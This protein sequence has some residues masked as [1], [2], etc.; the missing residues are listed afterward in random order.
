M[1]RNMRRVAL[2]LC[3]A[4]SA[5]PGAAQTWTY[6]ASEHFDVYAAG[7]DRQAREALTYFERVHA[8]FTDF[9]KLTPR[10]GPSTRIIAFTSDRQFAPY[11][12]NRIAD[13][14]YLTGPTGEFIVM[15][16]LGEDAYPIVVHEYAHLIFQR[17]GIRYPSWLDEG[18][19]EF[20]STMAPDGDRMGIGW[21][22][23]ARLQHLNGVAMLPLEELFAVTPGASEYNTRAHAGVFYSQSWALT[24]MLMTDGRYSGKSGALLQLVSKG[25]PSADAF[26][27]LYGKTTKDIGADLNSYARRGHYT[28]FRVTYEAPPPLGRVPTRAVDPFE[29]GLVTANLLANMPEREADARAAFERLGGEKPEDLTLLESWAYFELH[30]G[31]PGAALPYF[32]RAVE[33]GSKRAS[34]YRDYAALNPS[35]AETLLTTAF[36]L[37][38][39]DLDS[40][41]F[42]AG[43][44]VR[45]R[46]SA[47]AVATLSVVKE[48]PKESAFRLYR[49]L[50]NAHSQLDQIEEARAAVL[51][52]V[53]HARPGEEA[54]AAAALV[55]S[56]EEYALRRARQQAAPA[57][58]ETP[59][60]ATSDPRPAQR[61]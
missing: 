31:R 12:P 42:Y 46:K 21:P 4:F 19:A 2:L 43:L 39:A 45:Q 27:Q 1:P 5:S 57:R 8:F 61:P 16:S 17:S 26:A 6:A 56:I 32:A 50:A 3:F 33:A 40:R 9:L 29:A 38:P 54:A 28:Y 37:D 25:A 15:K 36:A 11:R 22:A 49:L 47:E 58:P 41:L 59:P 14:F 52:A 18:L 23:V 35:N 48:I 53:E 24:H 7:G 13:A 44:L 20:F 30:R 51:R 34:L 60:A 55:L 10:P